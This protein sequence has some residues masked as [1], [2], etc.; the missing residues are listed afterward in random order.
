[1]HYLSISGFEATLSTDG[2]PLA[3]FQLQSHG[4]SLLIIN[5]AQRFPLWPS[6]RFSPPWISQSTSRPQIRNFWSSFAKW[7]F[8]L[9]NSLA[10]FLTDLIH[11]FPKG[12]T[13]TLCVTCQQLLSPEIAVLCPVWVADLR[14]RCPF[15]RL[16][17][18]DGPYWS[19]SLPWLAF[20]W[21][22][23]HSWRLTCRRQLS[24]DETA[25]MSPSSAIKN[26]NL[27]RSFQDHHFEQR[28]HI[29]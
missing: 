27:G 11:W 6:E 22:L 12:T 2:W 7:R 29:G 3:C 14:S 10:Q 5:T 8:L 24:T 4:P 28:Y 13:L 1:M 16:F 18:L 23:C 19:P 25:L 26:G 21:Q 20:A 15:V 17:S 9:C